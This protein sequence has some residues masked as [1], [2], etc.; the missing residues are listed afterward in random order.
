MFDDLLPASLLTKLSSVFAK[1][2]PFWRETGY[3]REGGSGYFSFWSPL[4]SNGSGDDNN[5]IGFDGNDACCR[6]VSFGRLLGQ[7]VA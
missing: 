1:E 3:L 4:S 6:V 2:S 5:L 7:S